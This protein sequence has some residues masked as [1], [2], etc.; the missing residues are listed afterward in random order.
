LPESAFDRMLSPLH[1]VALSAV[2]LVIGTVGILTRR[3]LVVLLMSVELLLNAVNINLVTFGRGL[4]DTR[5]QIFAL[6]VI[7]DAVAEA[8]VGLAL[9]I[10]LYRNRET[11]LADELDLLK[12]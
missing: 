11:V 12:W 9:L 8:A 5:G 7:A 3:N 10:A 4:H 2:L 6:F 1:F